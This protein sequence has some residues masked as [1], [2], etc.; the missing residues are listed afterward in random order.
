MGRFDV[1]GKLVKRVCIVGVFHVAYGVSSLC[2]TYG[3]YTLR[4][5]RK[6]VHYW[7]LLRVSS[8]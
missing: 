5:K 3:V 2:H 1:L 8:R 4:S 6:T 7:V